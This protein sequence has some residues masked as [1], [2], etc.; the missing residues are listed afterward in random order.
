MFRRQSDWGIQSLFFI[1]APFIVLPGLVPQCIRIL[2]GPACTPDPSVLVEE[3]DSRTRFT[4]LAMRN[5][6]E[7]KLPENVEEGRI[8]SIY[9]LQ[10]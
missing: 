6:R 7:W 5:G 9:V 4:R 10:E 2:I 3:R 1:S 8:Q